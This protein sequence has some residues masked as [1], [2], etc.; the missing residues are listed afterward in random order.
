[1]RY[2]RLIEKIRKEEN[3]KQADLCQG[4]CSISTLSRIERGKKQADKMLLEALVERLGKTLVYWEK[5]LNNND[6]RLSQLQTKIN[7]FW[8]VMM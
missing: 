2:V 1:M 3:I 7:F 5:I 4:L 8:I 6:Q